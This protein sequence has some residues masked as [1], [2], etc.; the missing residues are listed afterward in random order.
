MAFI[1]RADIHGY[2]FVLIACLQ[3]QKVFRERS[4]RKTV[5]FEE[6]TMSKDKYASIFLRQIKAI[7]FFI[8]KLFLQRNKQIFRYC[9][10]IWGPKKLHATVLDVA[11]TT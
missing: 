6:R 8:L 4:L 9:L 1:W 2:L 7:V 10:L 5:S 3:I 11:P